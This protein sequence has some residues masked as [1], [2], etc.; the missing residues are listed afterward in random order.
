MPDEEWTIEYSA[1][2]NDPEN[3]AIKLAVEIKLRLMFKSMLSF[4]QYHLQ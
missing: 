2:L 1:Y 4:A 3:Q